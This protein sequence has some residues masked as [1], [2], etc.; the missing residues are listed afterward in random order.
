[1]LIN[2]KELLKCLT[3]QREETKQTKIKA[4]K[5]LCTH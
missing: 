3:A 5:K 2:S 1:M 4:N